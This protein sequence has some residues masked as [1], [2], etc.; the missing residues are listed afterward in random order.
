MAVINRFISL[1]IQK[2]VKEG[3]DCQLHIARDQE[4]F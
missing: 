1:N 2:V 4:S 3:N